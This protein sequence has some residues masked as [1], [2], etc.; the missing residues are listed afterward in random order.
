MGLYMVLIKECAVYVKERDFFISQK[1]DKEEW[2][3][4][5][6]LIEADSIEHARCKGM[7]I[8]AGVDQR[9]FH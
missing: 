5:W 9:T 2:G 4:T 6:K 1:G 7:L 8:R 3:K